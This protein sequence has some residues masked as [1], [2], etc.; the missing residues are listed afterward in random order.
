[1]PT[2]TTKWWGGDRPEVPS[3][4]LKADEVEPTLFVIRPA[5][6]LHDAVGVFAY[7]ELHAGTIIVPDDE[8]ESGI[9]VWDEFEKLDSLTRQHMLAYCVTV[10]DGISVPKYWPD[11]PVTWHMNHSCTPNVG[12]D[13]DDNLATL[14]RVQEGEELVW[15]YATCDVSTALRFE[16]R[17]GAVQCRKTVTGDDWKDPT[18][19]KSHL[20]SMTRS[21]R[22]R[23]LCNVLVRAD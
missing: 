8:P 9:L 13:A 18:F 3:R 15:D 21:L 10:D 1:M 19:A 5:A 4:V 12:F 2:D 17:C 23:V 6:Y 14:R 16:C 20:S 7:R 22:E 11:L